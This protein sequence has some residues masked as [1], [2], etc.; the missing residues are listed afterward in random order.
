MVVA[1]DRAER[2]VAGGVEAS[3]VPCVWVRG[4]ERGGLMPS[5]IVPR[6]GVFG[7]RVMV[8]YRQVWLGT[9]P[10]RE[11]ALEAV[12][13]AKGGRMP[14]TVTVIEWAAA[15]PDLYPGQ[16][17]ESTTVK[18]MEAI[19]PFVRE[20]G[21]RQMGSVGRLDAQAWANR[22]PHSVRYLRQM[23][24][25]AVK[26]GVVDFNPWALVEVPVRRRPQA[27]PSDSQLRALAGV[28]RERGW[29]RFADLIVFTAYSGL[30]LGEVAGVR[31]EDVR[32][33][34]R[35][36]LVRG[37][38]RAGEPAPRERVVAV[39]APGREALLRGMPEAGSVWRTAPGHRLSKDSIR[40]RFRAVR[41]EIEFPGTFHS[42]RHYHATWLRD[43]GADPRDI[44]SQ[45]GHT[46]AAGRPY[47]Q[48]I[49]RVY[50]HPD[51]ELALGRLEEVAG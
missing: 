36:V 3:F 25:K 19:A 9:Y 11:R 46:D 18:I 31:V 44:A 38:R 15:W 34:G 2:V 40:T 39:F 24:G 30:R 4:L 8:N 13:R 7:A 6:D 43:Q 50:A 33:D 29:E 21:H 22:S 1:D 51:P 5:N 16:R 26:G 48:L 23:W 12:K 17:L 35:R 49:D 28:A 27:V 45:L 47:P 14:T 41:D 10:T 20:Y 32:E 37:K 42:L